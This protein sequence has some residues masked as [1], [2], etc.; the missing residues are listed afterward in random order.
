MNSRYPFAAPG[1][2]K[3]KPGGRQ[4]RASA[5]SESQL[6][7]ALTHIP[8]VHFTSGQRGSGSSPLTLFSDLRLVLQKEFEVQQLYAK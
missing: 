8:R 5:I 6:A 7:T 1:D 2:A 4:D 3:S